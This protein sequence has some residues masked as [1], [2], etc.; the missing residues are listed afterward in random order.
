MMMT[1]S[2][3]G[4]RQAP[5]L[6]LTIDG[7]ELLAVE[8][9]TVAAALLAAGRRTLRTTPRRGEPR[10]LFCGMGVCFDCLIQVNGRPNLRACQTPAIDGM[11]LET[12]ARPRFLGGAGVIRQPLVIVGAGP[13]GMAAAIAAA[14]AGLRPLVIDENP[15]PGGQIY[16]QPPPSLPSAALA[17]QHATAR[18]GAD[19]LRRFAAL[20]ERMSLLSDTAVWGIFPPGAW[21]FGLPTA[22]ICWRR[23]SLSW[24]RGLTSMCR[25]SRAGPCPA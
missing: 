17:Q 11:R 3:P 22:G 21:R 16:R 1:D 2:Q 7:N 10:G 19:L 23:T 20:S 12:R 6:H 8:G 15:R 18:H 25:P 14:E 13:A 4:G 9:Q 5:L 24:R